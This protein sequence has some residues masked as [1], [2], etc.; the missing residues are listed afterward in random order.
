LPTEIHLTGLIGCN[1]SPM[2]NTRAKK[3]VTLN[4][5]VDLGK[6]TWAF[7]SP[8]MAWACFIDVDV[9]CTFTAGGH[10]VAAKVLHGVAG[11]P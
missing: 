5:D 3:L 1:L 11:H 2:R 4:A 8:S 10:E 6:T 9:L 7:P